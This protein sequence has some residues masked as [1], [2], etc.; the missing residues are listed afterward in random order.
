MKDDSSESNKASDLRCIRNSL[1]HKTAEIIATSLVHPV[2]TTATY[3]LPASQLHRL[4]L[5][6]NALARAASRT[7]L[8]SQFPSVLHS[9]HWLNIEQRIR[10]KIISITNNLSHSSTPS[11]LYRL[12]NIQP[13]RP[14]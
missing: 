11:Y 12:L 9:F 1:S 5:M 2:L 4:Q 6:Q 3:S 10:Y 14:T 7:P 13:T 8:H